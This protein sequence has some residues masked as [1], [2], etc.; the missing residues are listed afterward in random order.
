MSKL[1]SKK[2][3]ITLSKMQTQVVVTALGNFCDEADDDAF[4]DEFFFIAEDLHK[5]F[6][7]LFDSFEEVEIK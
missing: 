1:E 3:P 5:L 4:S 6:M 2:L 7:K